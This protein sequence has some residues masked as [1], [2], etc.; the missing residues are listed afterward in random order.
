MPEFQLPDFEAI[1]FNVPIF[2][3]E[4]GQPDYQ[5]HLQQILVAD[6][7]VVDL[8]TFTPDLALNKN[9]GLHPRDGRIR[10]IQLFD[11]KTVWIADLRG[12]DMN[13]MPLFSHL[14]SERD[15]QHK[16]LQEFLKC[17]AID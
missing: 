9:N 13:A 1:D 15:A 8:E 4:P 5:D 6:L 10:L 14:P 3:L 2:M 7:L 16:R 17:W 11:G 12:R